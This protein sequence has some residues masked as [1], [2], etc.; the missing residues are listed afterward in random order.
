[1]PACVPACLAG[2]LA[3]CLPSCLSFLAFFLS[4][5]LSDWLPGWLAGRWSPGARRFCANCSSALT[6]AEVSLRAHIACACALLHAPLLLLCQD[7]YLKIVARVT[8]ESGFWKGVHFMFEIHFPCEK[9]NDYPMVPPKCVMSIC[10]TTSLSGS[11]CVCFGQPC[12]GCCVAALK[13]FSFL[14]SF[15]CVPA[16]NVKVPTGARL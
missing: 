4:L 10:V 3:A 9:P 15:C 8:C 7:S 2:Q 12:R 6:G 16:R 13:L 1:M 14:P 11:V 5:W